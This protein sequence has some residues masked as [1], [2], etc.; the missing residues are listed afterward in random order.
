MAFVIIKDKDN[1][2][3]GHLQTDAQERLGIHNFLHVQDQKAT[4]ADG[5]TFT[6]G[7]WRTRELNT[8]VTN[9]IA[10]ASLADN[11]VTLPAGQYYSASRANA[12]SVGVHVARLYNVSDSS[13][14]LNGSTEVVVT[15]SPTQTISF[16]D[17][18]FTLSEETTIE[19]Q[20]SCAA[21]C[22]TSGFGDGH[23]LGQA[24]EIFAD[25]KIWK[26]A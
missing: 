24:Y 5:G 22:G 15:D 6:S 12:K 9:N 21:T 13:V 25:L 18:L 11:Q 7:A 14:L 20:H 16:V 17:G 8:V 23:N 1:A 19:L 4:G 2:T 10:G 3:L 26:V